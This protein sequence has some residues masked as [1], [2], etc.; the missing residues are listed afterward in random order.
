MREPS[1]PGTSINIARKK[2]WR[3]R[4]QHYRYPPS[5]EEITAFL[6]QFGGT[7]KDTAARLLDAVEVVSHVQ[8]EESFQAL[9]QNLPGWHRSKTK[10][11]GRWRFVPYS[12][13]SGESGDLMISA[14]RQAMG[15]KQRQYNELFIHPSDL[16]AQKL[17]GEDTVVLVDDFSGSGKQAC[18]SWNDLF[19]EL[20]GGVGTVYLMVVAATTAAQDAIR[21]KTEL[22]VLCH[23]NLGDSD[24][25][26]AEA[27]DHFSEAEKATILARCTKH[28]A[29]EPRGYGDCGLLF[30]LHH[31]CPNNSIPLLHKHSKNSWV[32]LF[33]RTRSKAKPK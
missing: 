17:R 19:R 28:F 20:V 3:D 30:V 21:D 18:D 11:T 26:F 13:S 32:P 23:Y 7:E 2:A 29:D 33:A 16:V 5:I 22:E 25:L 15:M 10:R 1:P 4:F 14:F 9:M 27:C 6:K 31:D 8:I 12:F 24:N